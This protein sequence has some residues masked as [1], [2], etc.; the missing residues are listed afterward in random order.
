MRLEM[1]AMARR[2][3]GRPLT[4]DPICAPTPYGERTDAPMDADRWPLV[5]EHFHDALGLEGDART[6]R[7][8]RLDAEMRAEVQALLDAAEAERVLD[9]PLDTDLIPTGVERLATLHAQTPATGAGPLTGAAVGP[10]RVGARIGRGGM[11]DVYCALRDD[12]LFERAVALKVVRDGA[13]TEAVLARFAAERRILGSLEHP[14]IARLIAAG[15]ERDGPAAG[16]PWLALE[17]VDGVPITDAAGALPLR[18]RV[19]LMAEVAEAVHHAHRRLVVHRDLKPSNVLV[20]TDDHGAHHA[21]LLDFGI[22]K[23]LDAEADPMLTEL[24]QRRPMTRAYAAPEQVRGG[25]VT[26]ATDVYGLGLLLFEVLAGTRPFAVG[27]DV[28]ALEDAIL[29]TDAPAPSTVAL[30]GG[31]D[32]RRLRGD[33]DVI[34]RT[35]LAK[36]PEAR[37]GSAEAFADDLRR[38]LAAEPIAARAPSALYRARRFVRRNRTGVGATVLGV[39]VVAAGTALSLVSLAA[40]RDRARSAAQEAEAVTEMMVDMFDRDPFAADAERLDTVSVGRFVRER[41]DAAAARLDDRPAAQA[42]LLAMLSRLD[43]SLGDNERALAK[44]RRAVAIVDSL[45]GPPSA[46][47]ARVHD[48]LGR[49][50]EIRG[51]YAGA[52]RAYRTAL[53][54]TEAVF[55]AESAEAASVLT[56]LGNALGSSSEPAHTDEA[57]AVARRALALSIQTLG[58][59]HIDVA[60]AHNNLSA[61]LY[62]VDREAEAIPHAERALAIRKAA[63]GVHP[64]VGNTQSNLASY[65]RETGRQA[66]AVALY[67]DA[68]ATYTATLGADHPSLA[69]PHY[70]RARALRDLGRLADA[71]AAARDALR[72]DL[73]AL[74]DDHPFLVY[75]YELLGEIL[76]LRGRWREAEPT[77]RTGLGIAGPEAAPDDVA[78]LRAALGRCLARTGRPGA[79]RE[80]LRAALPHLDGAARDRARADLDALG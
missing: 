30:A 22:A 18:A 26:T 50:R 64:L 67:D 71:E 44:A 59:D 60:Q 45:G 25:A 16:R 7:L 24:H 55:G 39:L 74:P 79:A 6:A 61:Q 3:E 4:R 75:D 41:G 35:A 65:L 9:Q 77:L 70:G 1:Q 32:A 19:A 42:R 34:C 10:Y 20:C 43:A 31:V 48:E 53:R 68:I 5:K 33:L 46:V 37:Y 13:D 29:H 76:T 21:K 80:H 27:G 47:T 51:D 17:L 8:D 40:E 62:S 12:G 78:T 69:A 49:V 2:S 14:G 73:A 58:A 38:W 23:L 66:D 56:N 15:A 72:A 57:A 52:I 28:R 63:L 36:E 54:H 11:G